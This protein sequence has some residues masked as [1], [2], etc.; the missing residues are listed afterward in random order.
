M[1]REVKQQVSRVAVEGLWRGR[2]AR[3]ARECGA[4]GGWRGADGRAGGRLE[5][6]A[7]QDQIVGF[8]T[9]L[10]KVESFVG[11]RWPSCEKRVMSAL[12]TSEKA[13]KHV[14]STLYSASSLPSAISDSS[15]TVELL[16]GEASERG[17]VDFGGGMLVSSSQMVKGAASSWSW[18]EGEFSSM[19]DMFLRGE[20]IGAGAPSMASSVTKGELVSSSHVM[21]SAL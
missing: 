2:R 1:L 17:R 9:W 18:T 6:L 3:G 12:G 13:L 8:R 14:S 4:L 15:V 11:L 21:S 7:V 19:I 10:S 16:R 20:D 5:P